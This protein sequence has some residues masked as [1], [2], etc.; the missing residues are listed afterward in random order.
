MTSQD[1]YEQAVINA[2][3]DLK[4]CLRLE[5]LDKEYVR[6]ILLECY[7]IMVN[8]GQCVKIHCLPESE[9]RGLW[10]EAKRISTNPTKRKAVALAIHSLG[11]FI[12]CQ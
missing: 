8:N 11:N 3:A 6:F 1:P 4:N 9:K 5:D 2:V 10:E 12:Q 7:R